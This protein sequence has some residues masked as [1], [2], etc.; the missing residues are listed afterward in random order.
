MQCGNYQPAKM[1]KKVTLQQLTRVSDSQ[2]GYTETWATVITASASLEPVK[3]YER[4]QGGQ[5]ETPVTHKAAMRYDSRI[6]TAK[7]L[8]YGTRV[9]QI[10]GCINVKE[11]NAFMELTCIE[12]ATAS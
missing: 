4:F 11:A 12:I 6:T 9:F 7:R 10:K 8:L 2:G 1:N 3:S 5:T